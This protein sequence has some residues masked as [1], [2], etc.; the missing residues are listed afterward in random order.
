M[1]FE[2]QPLSLTEI[3]YFYH[4][5]FIGRFLRQNNQS[6][7]WKFKNQLRII[8]GS[9]RRFL[10]NHKAQNFLCD[11]Y[12]KSARSDELGVTMFAQREPKQT[13]L[14]IFNR[15]QTSFLFPAYDPNMTFKAHFQVA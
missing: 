9:K 15:V 6:I 4:L 11:S 12:K 13:N 2:N 5:T 1:F 14:K 8:S 10:K 3:P 7:T